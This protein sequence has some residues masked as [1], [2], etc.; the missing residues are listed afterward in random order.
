MSKMSK[1]SDNE[2]QL[3]RLEK[4]LLNIEY[5]EK[6]KELENAKTNKIK[7]I[8]IKIQGLGKISINTIIQL[9]DQIKQNEFDV[10]IFDIE[11]TEINKSLSYREDFKRY[12]RTFFSKKVQDDEE[13]LTDANIELFKTHLNINETQ[14]KYKY[15]ADKLQ[16]AL[17][18]V[19][20]AYR[21][22]ELKSKRESL[23][24]INFEKADFS[25]AELEKINKVITELSK[26]NTHEF[27]TE[28]AQNILAVDILYARE[29]HRFYSDFDITD[30]IHQKKMQNNKRF[31]FY[32]KKGSLLQ[33]Y[34]N[35]MTT[36]LRS[37]LKIEL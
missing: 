19:Q 20:E 5:E 12:C 3:E 17:I 13:E 29:Q 6:L 22:L 10:E 1:I 16:E 27:L 15:I 37:T 26:Y 14:R 33:L 25:K 8:K 18:L 30:A 34:S 28:N 9:I 24:K 7:G 23:N 11:E 2:K 32:D 35:K 4:S 31:S 36:L 21:K